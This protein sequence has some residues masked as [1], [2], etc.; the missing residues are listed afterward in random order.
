MLVNVTLNKETAMRR[1]AHLCLAAGVVMF[2][3]ALVGCLNVQ[4]EPRYLAS[5]P[6]KS[7]M[8]MQPQW[9]SSGA[10]EAPAPDATPR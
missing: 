7:D 2:V 6:A 4:H 1:L 8:R 3:C 5:D 9:S 10:S